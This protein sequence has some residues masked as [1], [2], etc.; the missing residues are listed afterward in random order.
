M[1]NKTLLY[2]RSDSQGSCP[3]DKGNP[4]PLPASFER[5]NINGLT[6]KE[7]ILSQ[8][9]VALVDDEDYGLLNQFKWCAIKQ[10]RTFYAAKSVKRNGKWTSERM[11]RLFFDI[12]MGKE[13]DHIDH[14]GLNNQK[15]NLRLVTRQQNKQNASAWGSS[16]YLGV[17]V[18]KQEGC[19]YI[20]AHIQ[21]DG[22][23]KHLGLFKTEEDAA[24]A[25]NRA[26]KEKYGEYAN[27]NKIE[28]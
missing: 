3:D 9:K 21:I 28:P 17:C 14:N 22:K 8:G 27:L 23:T 4:F 13:I 11:H 1:F 7:I 20:A 18:Y 25:Y 5:D 2:L 26:A 10:H 16:K 12:P 15:S 24:L 19:T 6:M